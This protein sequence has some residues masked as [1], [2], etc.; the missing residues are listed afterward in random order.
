MSRIGDNVAALR[1]RASLSQAQAAQAVGVRQAT[2][3][4]WESGKREPE[5]P[6]VAA[7]CALFG[8]TA[9]DLRFEDLT[10]RRA[11]ADRSPPA[12]LEEATRRVRAIAS[13]LEGDV[14]LWGGG[15]DHLRAMRVALAA[16]DTVRMF[17]NAPTER[18]LAAMFDH[19]MRFVE[20]YRLT[21]GDRISLGSSDTRP[22]YV[23][24][25]ER[26]GGKVAEGSR[27]RPT[28]HAAETPRRRRPRG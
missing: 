11:W 6:N 22:G 7:L 24:A 20:A 1:K 26:F 16:D 4:E 14:H 28:E 2:W 21:L 19:Y 9:D 23:K 12:N 25:A 8:V 13:R 17:S 27:T 15:E 10:V 3:S 18:E 5:P